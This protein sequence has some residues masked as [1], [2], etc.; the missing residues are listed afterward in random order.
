M[1]DAYADA[2]T[3][4][5]MRVLVAIV[6]RGSFSGAARALQRS[7][8][9]VSYQIATLEAQLDLVLFRR[10]RRRPVLTAEGRAIVGSARRVLAELET[11]RGRA[12]ALGAG[13]EPVVRLAVD[14]L[15]PS[16]RLADRLQAFERKYG[17]VEVELLMAVRGQPA[18]LLTDGAADVA[19]VPEPGDL[20]A[21]ACT[22][23]ELIPVA[24][25]EHPLANHTTPA[26]DAVLA[27]HLRLVL[28]DETTEAE[29]ARARRWRLNDAMV[30]RDLLLAGVGWCTMPRH[31]IKDD[32]T[33]GRLVRIRTHRF[34]GRGVI[35]PLYA[36]HHR[37]RALGPA[38]RW[39]F[40]RL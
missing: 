7:Q 21:R 11:L 39:W 38:S 31:Q 18:R 23:A 33:A 12:R 16:Q 10:T 14:V 6:D 4:D 34:P 24:A 26:T 17:D 40:D 13:L 8:S 29:P 27:T 28:A 25:P 32:L 30:R 5:Q 2:L 9:A 36:A 1:T 22:R 15:Y 37:D 20:E 35:V 19:V 3:A